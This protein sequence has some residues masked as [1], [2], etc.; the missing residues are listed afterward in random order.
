[1]SAT[2]A[3][4]GENASDSL[5][6]ARAEARQFTA[7]TLPEAAAARNGLAGADRLAA[8]FERAGGTQPERAAVRQ[9]RVETSAWR[10]KRARTLATSALAISAA[11]LAGCVGMQPPRTEAPTPYVLDARPAESAA[12]PLRDVVLA[13]SCHRARPGYDTA[14]IALCVRPQAGLLHKK[15]LGGYPVAHAGAASGSGTG[16][17]R[18]ISRRGAGDQADSGR[19]AARY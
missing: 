4:T 13:V 14:R 18:R 10:M 15:S 5:D 7:E 3:R 11:L 12:R 16:A 1:M 17:E 8:A 9:A 6:R 2:I 19:L